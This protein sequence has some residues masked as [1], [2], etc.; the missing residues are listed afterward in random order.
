MIPAAG[1]VALGEIP[2][3]AA[4]TEEQAAEERARLEWVRLRGGDPRAAVQELLRPAERHHVNKR[5]MLALVD[6]AH[7]DDVADI[8]A[9]REDGA[10]RRVGEVQR[11]LLVDDELDGCDGSAGEEQ[12]VDVPDSCSAHRV[13]HEVFT[14]LVVAYRN[15]AATLPE[16]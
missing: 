15:P 1:V 16:P 6:V 3:A 12:V 10:D 2:G 4:P 13:R 7:P 5:L 14:H 11:V 8:Q 9:V